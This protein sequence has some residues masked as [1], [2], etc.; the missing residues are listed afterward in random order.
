M[1]VCWAAMPVFQHRKIRCRRIFYQLKPLAGQ[2][3]GCDMRILKRLRFPAGTLL[4]L[5]ASGCLI[6]ERAPSHSSWPKPVAAKDLQQFEGVYRNHSL[7]ASCDKHLEG[8]TQLFDFLTGQGH[9]HG[10]NGERVEVRSAQDGSSLCVRLF[11]QENRQIES[12]TL[13]RGTAFAFSD[14]ALV[15]YGPLSGLRNN[16]GNFGPNAQYQRDKLSLASTGGLLGHERQDEVGLLFDV[17]PVASTSG[18]SMFWPKL[19]P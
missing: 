10:T 15:L 13:Q 2:V 5:L 16:S 19:A 9:S 3:Y 6:V 12:A 11:D 1:P 7:E 4:A 14:G 18:K 17:I 8:G